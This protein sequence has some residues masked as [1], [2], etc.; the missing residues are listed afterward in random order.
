[1]P[2]E[3]SHAGLFP[4]AG[5]PVAARH[6]RDR[7]G[8]CAGLLCADAGRQPPHP[9]SP[10]HPLHRRQWHRAGLRK[11]RLARVRDDRGR[12]PRPPPSSWPPAPT[13]TTRGLSDRAVPARETPRPTRTYIGQ[14]RIRPEAAPTASSSP[15]KVKIQIEG[16]DRHRRALRHPGLLCS[17]CHRG[18]TTAAMWSMFRA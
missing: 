11:R 18:T 14:S 4:A 10:R 8:R 15:R 5:I 13:A 6:G 1:M 9:G 17:P 16:A 3:H 2:N 12:H 7:A